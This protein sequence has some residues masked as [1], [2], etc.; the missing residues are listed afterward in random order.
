[1]G[2]GVPAQITLIRPTLTFHFHLGSGFT[3]GGL[4]CYTEHHT[5]GWF[6]MHHDPSIA[7]PTPYQPSVCLRKRSLKKLIHMG[8]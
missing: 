4:N 7:L 1:M 5:R 8:A 2:T 6:I 3:E